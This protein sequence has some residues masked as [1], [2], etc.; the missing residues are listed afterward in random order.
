MSCNCENNDN[1]CSTC[2][3]GITIPVGPMGAKGDQGDQGIVG[4]NGATGP[5]GPEGPQGE[6]STVVGPVGPEGPQGEPGETAAQGDPG[7]QGPAGPQGL[8]GTNGPEGPE[9]PEGPQGP[10]GINSTVFD[11]YLNGFT[12][13]V[14]PAT[15]TLV[16]GMTTTVGSGT[17][18][19]LIMFEL[20]VNGNSI[21]EV[22]TKIDGVV[23]ET[24]DITALSP[25]A[26][27]NI[28]NII[29]T[30]VDDGKD[31]E[32]FVKDAAVAAT[33]SGFKFVAI[34]LG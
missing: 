5:T 14:A 25:S 29:V 27:T 20:F 19:Y 15:S 33:I 22:V 16:P 34:R 1:N 31:I 9:G 30:N 28:S 2:F 17:G 3:D 11:S 4:L 13:F 24:L 7:P 26:G 12:P 23:F 10:D 21:D 6:D 32:V 18:N 8:P